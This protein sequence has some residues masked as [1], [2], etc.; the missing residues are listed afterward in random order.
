VKRILRSAALLGIAALLPLKGYAAAGSE[1]ASFLEIPV[2]AGP[3]A[4]GSAYTALATNAYAPTWN[5]AGLGLI[6]G[7]EV[8]AQHLAYLESIHYEYLSGVYP[9]PEEK[10]SSTHRG[11]GFSAQYLGSGDITAT[12]QTGNSIGSFSSHYGA[13]NL[14]YGQTLGEKFALGATTKW[15]NAGIADVSA[16]AF[17]V[18][19]GG[20]YR[21]T[22]KLNLGTSLT[23]IG[24]PLKFISEGDSLPLAWHLGAAYTASSHWL[25]TTEGVYEK[26]GMG[27]FHIGGEWRPLEAISMRLGYKTDTLSGLSAIAGLTAGLGIHAWGQEFAY[28]WAP[29]GDL[30]NAQYFSVLVHFGE[31]EEAKRNLIQ[32]QTI[33]KHRTVR[34]NQGERGEKGSEPEY[35]QLMQLLSDDESHLAQRSGSS[36]PR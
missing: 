13:Y 27:S 25:V 8:A 23:N 14:S 29:Y 35:Q 26:Y 34:T 11:I 31:R 33:K 20:M 30:G 7:T 10:G 16:N 4:M 18:D 3:A 6:S 36:N 2:G 19:L 22:S 15:I 12:D 32:Y 28:A 24:T 5:P 21:P 9:L 17:G 1:G